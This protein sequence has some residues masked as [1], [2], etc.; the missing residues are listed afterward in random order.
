MEGGGREP[1]SRAMGFAVLAG[2]LA[3]TLA[4]GPDFPAPAWEA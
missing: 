4:F 3:S 1:G 2:G